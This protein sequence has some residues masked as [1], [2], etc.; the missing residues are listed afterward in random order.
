[1]TADPTAAPVERV[2]AGAPVD[3]RHES[4]TLSGYLRLWW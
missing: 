3:E 1:V 2:P 4:Q